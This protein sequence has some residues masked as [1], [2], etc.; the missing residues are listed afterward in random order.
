MTNLERITAFDRLRKAG[1]NVSDE[2]ANDRAR[3]SA[4]KDYVPAIIGLVAAAAIIALIAFG[5]W[6][7]ARPK[8]DRFVSDIVTNCEAHNGHAHVYRAGKEGD[9]AV[10]GVR[11]LRDGAK[12]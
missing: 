5:I 12:P 2:L 1:E 8:D 11:C 6:Q 7:H 9:G 3:W 4:K 10:L